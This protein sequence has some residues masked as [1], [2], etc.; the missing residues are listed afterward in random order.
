M[1]FLAVLIIVTSA[2]LVHAADMWRFHYEAEKGDSDVLIPRNAASLQTFKSKLI[3]GS[4]DPLDK[5]ASIS[6]ATSKILGT[7]HD[8][9]IVEIRLQLKEG[10][11]TDIYLL[12]IQTKSGTYLPIY[13]QQYN[14]CT[15]TPRDI[16]FKISDD[17]GIISVTMLYFGTEGSRTI[18]KIQLEYDPEHGVSAQTKR[19]TEQ[20]AAANP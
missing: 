7:F 4:P 15:R 3:Q 19:Q 12:L 1:K 9:S 8:R 14:R 17:I 2:Q 18:D 16:D 20:D 5:N 6:K 13:A 11:Y 10:F